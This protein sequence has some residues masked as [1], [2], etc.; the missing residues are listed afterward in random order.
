VR[1]TITSDAQSGR[2][3]VE[4]SL[5]LRPAHL[6]REQIGN[7]AIALDVLAPAFELALGHRLRHAT[8]CRAM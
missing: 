4:S 1:V 7:V 8:S 5:Y 6:G 2:S 3:S